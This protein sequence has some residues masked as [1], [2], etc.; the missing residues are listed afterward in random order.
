MLLGFIL[1]LLYINTV[2]ELKILYSKA[3]NFK[4]KV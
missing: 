1:S 3:A 2:H 4:G